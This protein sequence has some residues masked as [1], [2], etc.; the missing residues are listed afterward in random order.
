MHMIR[1]LAPVLLAILGTGGGIA[2]GLM[3]RPAEVA[4]PETTTAED[5]PVA[6]VH[7]AHDAT[8][9][10]GNT[11]FVKLNNQ[12]VVPVVT[13]DRISAMVVMSLSVEIAQGNSQ[14]VY[15]REPKLRD[16]FLQLLFD[17]ANLGGF[18]GE[19][20]NANN[21]DVLRMA[22]HDAATLVL[23]DA[24]RGVL[25]TEIARQDV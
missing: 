23:G 19:F 8:K 12:F 13:R 17:H 24:A 2:A 16:G 25:I 4:A 22:L 18:E 1:K 10:T 15:T 9:D 11:E 6:D 14:L 7:D 21:M 5:H 3:L 20:P